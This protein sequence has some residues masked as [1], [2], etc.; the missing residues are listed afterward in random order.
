VR[1]LENAIESVVALS[2][3][4]QFD[5]NVLP[6]ESTTSAVDET[7]TAA[8]AL[9]N[10]CAAPDT[11]RCEDNRS[12]AARPWHRARQLHEKLAKYGI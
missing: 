8:V 6:S 4:G 12:E 1:E 10:E 2:E 3:P 11:R 7:G 9:A 5:L